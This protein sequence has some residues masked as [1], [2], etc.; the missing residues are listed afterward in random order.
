MTVVQL[1]ALARE[2]GHRGTAVDYMKKE[3]LIKLLRR[4]TAALPTGNT[5]ADE[6]PLASSP[7]ATPATQSSVDVL[8]LIAHA[9]AQQIP[10]QTVDRATVEKMVSEAIKKASA[11]HE[12]VAMSIQD[13]MSKVATAL[14]ALSSRLP[15]IVE[16]KKLDGTLQPLG[17]QHKAFLRLLELVNV[18]LQSP[19]P[20]NIWLVGPAGTGKTTAAEKIA[21]ALGMPFYFNGALDTEYKLSGFVNAHGQVVSTAF[22][23]AFVNGGVYLFDEVDSSLP[24]ALLAFNTA[25]ANHHYDFPD[26]VK[27][28]HAQFVCIAAANTYGLGADAVYV[29]RM[30]QDGAF[31]DRFIQLRWD[32]D[33][34]MERILAQHD[35]WVDYV[36]QIR[37]KVKTRGMQ[38]VISPRASYFGATLLRAGIPKEDVI[39]YSV[40]KAMTEDQWRQVA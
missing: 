28:R 40:R 39:E 4:E 17:I 1:K 6:L 8:G 24:R 25:L 20:I 19:V 33:E 27:K 38:V 22:R 10:K 23:Q 16:I 13:T 26:G 18:A 32:I 36:Q 3:E 34:D 30:K 7:P 31:L 9:V 14:D 37:Q 5:V 11:S 2:Q 35:E 21:E 29:G 12:A 15:T